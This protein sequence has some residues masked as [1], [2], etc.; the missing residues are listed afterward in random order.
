MRRRRCVAVLARAG[1]FVASR[2]ILL[3]QARV[4][5]GSAGA[6]FIGIVGMIASRRETLMCFAL[7]LSGSQISLGAFALGSGEL[8]LRRCPFGLR[9]G[10]AFLGAEHMIV[11]L[12]TTTFEL[13]LFARG[14]AMTQT[15][16][17]H[18]PKDDENDDDYDDDDDRSG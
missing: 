4:E 17:K 18:C 6:Q 15:R 10:A 7:A 9:A 5:F 1:T 14:L 12:C 13:S 2:R 8:L 11:R 16:E 3:T